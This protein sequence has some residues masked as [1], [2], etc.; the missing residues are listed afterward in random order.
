M[1]QELFSEYG[2]GSGAGPDTG[3]SAFMMGGISIEYNEKPLSIT[4]SLGK[5]FQL[6]LILLYYS[7]EGVA[8]EALLDMLYGSGEYSNPSGSLRAVVFRLRKC[9]EQSGLPPHDYIRIEG[10]I[11]RWDGGGLPLWVDAREFE[12]R[13]VRGL[14]SRK[15]ELLE[16][17][18]TLYRGEFLT[19]LAGEKWVP[20][21]GARLQELYFKCL[22]MLYGILR[23]SRDYSR[24]LRLCS[25]ACKLYPYEE[26]Q[27][28]RIDCLIAMKRFKEARQEYDAAVSQYFEEQGLPPSKEMLKRFRM[29]SGQLSLASDHLEDIGSALGEEERAEGPYYCSYPSFIDCYRLL[30]RIKERGKL[31]NTLLSCTLTQEIGAPMDQGEELFRTASVKLREA[32]QGS[33]RKGDV[34]TSSG[35]GRYLILL[36]GAE[37]I[38]CKIVCQRINRNFQL[39][40]NQ[41]GRKRICLECRSVS[42]K[43]MGTG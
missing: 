40:Q 39:W 2:E 36:N 30:E 15:W 7:E 12:R 19:Q 18:C 26:C 21:I 25:Y 4:A 11:Y 41:W 29:M 17:A 6:F 38:N 24:L 13:A 35:A 3:L 5:S 43:D 8:R 42:K 9:L 31:V 34:F 27:I 22:R 33:L 16:Q 1:D 23:K 14:E 37:E 20:S 10:G 32:I 28:M